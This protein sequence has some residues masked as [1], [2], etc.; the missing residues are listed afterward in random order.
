LTALTYVITPV[1]PD[2][3]Y[4]VTPVIPYVTVTPVVTRVKLVNP[5]LIHRRCNTYIIKEI[6]SG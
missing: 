1:I 2:V 3:T 6:E 5:S 4:M